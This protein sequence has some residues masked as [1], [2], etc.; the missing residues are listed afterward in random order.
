MGNMFTDNLYI[1]NLEG[2]DGHYHQYCSEFAKTKLDT[3]GNGFRN[4]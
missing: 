4:F 1:G 3:I 2:R